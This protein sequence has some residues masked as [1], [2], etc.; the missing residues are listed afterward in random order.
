MFTQKEAM[1]NTIEQGWFEDYQVLNSDSN[2]YNLAIFQ[3]NG[4]MT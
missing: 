4:Y 3:I 1:S 2:Y